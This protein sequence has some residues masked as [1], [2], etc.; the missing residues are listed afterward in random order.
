V[1]AAA[2][3]GLEVTKLG[4]YGDDSPW[5][6]TVDVFEDG[7]IVRYQV[8]GHYNGWPDGPPERTLDEVARVQSDFERRD[9]IAEKLDA[10]DRQAAAEILPIMERLFREQVRVV[11][12][13]EGVAFLDRGTKGPIRS[14][15]EGIDG[16]GES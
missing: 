9:E 11:H 6:M 7:K 8:T 12:G 5:R 13:D 14:R 4:D 2:I 10:L 3:L 15:G 16:G 1:S